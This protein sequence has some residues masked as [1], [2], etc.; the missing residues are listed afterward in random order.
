MPSTDDPPELQFLGAIAIVLS[1][2]IFAWLFSAVMM[3]AFNLL[4]EVYG[5][6]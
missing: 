6:S 3:E 2:I 4:V 5:E 1:I